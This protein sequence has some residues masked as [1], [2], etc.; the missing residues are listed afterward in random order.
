MTHATSL[1]PERSWLMADIIDL[2]EIAKG[3]DPNIG[4]AATISKAI[5]PSFATGFS[6]D[7]IGV[8]NYLTNAD[9]AIDSIAKTDLGRRVIDRVVDLQQE[10]II[11]GFEDVIKAVG[12]PANMLSFARMSY[13]PDATNSG[14]LQWPGVHP[15]ALKKILR[16][17]V[18]P[19]LIVNTRVDDVLRYSQLS[20][21]D[22][23]P[24]WR[25]EVFQ[26]REKK[27]S[28]NDKDIREA[29]A[30]LSN[31][32]E[33]YGYDKAL[34]REDKNLTDFQRFSAA[35]ARDSL[36]F[37]GIAINT[38]RDGNNRVKSWAPLPAGNMRLV[39]PQGYEGN[40]NLFMVAV[41]EGGKVV[42][43]YKREELIW[44]VRNIRTDPEWTV[45]MTRCY[46][47]PEI[48]MTLRMIQ[49][50]Q[51]IID[52]NVDIFNR[53][54]VPNGMLILTGNG[55]IQRQVDV[56]TRMWHNL[57]R[58]I[59]KSHAIPVLA[60]P[61]DSK[62]E[63]VDL[64]KIKGTEAL[65]QDMLNLMIGMFCTMFR[66]P[67]QRFGYRITGNGPLQRHDSRTQQ[68]I[69]LDE[70]PGL[71]VLLGHLERIINQHF[72]WPRWA[73]LKFSY[74][75]K[76]PKEAAREYEFKRNALT[77]GEAR[78]EVDLPELASL[79]SNSEHKDLAELMSL[80]PIDANLSGIFQTIAGAYV[81][82]SMGLEGDAGEPGGKMK[83]KKDP[84]ASETHG[85]MSGIRRN[86]RA[87]SSNGTN[88]N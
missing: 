75:G 12:I 9:L 7:N 64:S 84:A 17:N 70:D 85:H 27:S 67:V 39:G 19:N 44:Y 81:K 36:T 18:A 38:E 8:S 41:D 52:Y 65:Y 73:N 5:L 42:K 3:Y 62:V 55:W 83:E 71:V 74:T 68:V 10:G 77:W 87:E 33:D 40:K 63:V 28:Q 80:A 11:K 72:I 30:F 76:D 24:G 53:N 34:E 43:A 56:L 22:W 54:G 21:H 78:T 32:C 37:D 46:G 59:T 31:S 25:I 26:G 45:S 49:G 47:T 6:T 51:N 4:D 13:M 2:T 61:Q 29:E 60:A 50:V 14:V 69:E 23:R 79:V 86:S 35:I 16:E 88:R 15:E 1:Q 66:F 20:T 82:A 57:K 48:D 58:G